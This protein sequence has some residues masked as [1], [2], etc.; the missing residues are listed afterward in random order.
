MCFPYIRF[1]L[2]LSWPVTIKIWYIKCEIIPKPMFKLK[3]SLG[4]N[5]VI[6]TLLKS[7]TVI[8]SRVGR[9]SMSSHHIGID[10]LFRLSSS[11]ASDPALNRY[12]EIIEKL[13]L[14]NSN[15]IQKIL[16]V[17]KVE[18]FV[19]FLGMLKEIWSITPN[20]VSLVKNRKSCCYCSAFSRYG[21][22]HRKCGGNSTNKF[23][24]KC[25]V[26][27]NSCPS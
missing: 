4:V 22:P 10:V 16:H 11:L 24:E 1:P 12:K 21:I 17:F 5:I 2:S 9:L 23:A 27:W 15:V 7:R 3:V 18:K 26:E 6:H 14:W 25:I 13:S 19:C 8:F 20:W